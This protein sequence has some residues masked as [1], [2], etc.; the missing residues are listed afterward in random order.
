M[1]AVC[2]TNNECTIPWKIGKDLVGIILY[3]VMGIFYLLELKQVW[4][5]MAY[6]NGCYANEDQ[7]LKKKHQHSE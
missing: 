1:Q 3:I 7:E 5:P 4:N 2:G 6:H